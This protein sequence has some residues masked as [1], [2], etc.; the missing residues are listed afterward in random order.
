MLAY[1]H[2][3]GQDIEFI[4]PMYQFKEIVDMLDIYMFEN[5]KDD[6]YLE[7]ISG[8]HIPPIFSS[9]QE[10]QI[11]SIENYYHGNVIDL[12]NV[13]IHSETTSLLWHMQNDN[14]YQSQYIW[15]VDRADTRQPAYLDVDDI[16]TDDPDFCFLRKCYTEW[17]NSNYKNGNY[18]ERDGKVSP[19]KSWAK[20]VVLRDR[21]ATKILD[22]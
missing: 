1:D 16:L 14:Q 19:L 11:I 17:L 15:I 5:F 3:Y 6:G 9:T 18:V 20:Q 22:T 13:N 10:Q 2:E 21:N 12:I 4:I 8:E 7:E